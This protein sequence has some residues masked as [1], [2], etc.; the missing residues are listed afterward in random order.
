MDKTTDNTM[1]IRRKAERYCSESERC[2]EEVMQKL[3]AWQA[4]ET[5][6]EAILTYLYEQGYL[7]D[8]RYCRAFV[9][10]KVRFAQWGRVKIRYAL[11][12]KQLPEDAID[13]AM[14]EID[15]EEY[16]KVLQHLATAYCSAKKGAD[17][18]RLIRYLMQRGFTYEEI[19]VLSVI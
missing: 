14:N 2:R 10:D 3:T 5:D 16:K 18:N 19:S 12:A 8:E 15:T 13:K 4:E 1:V 6:I 9:H 17:Q 11:R 7:N